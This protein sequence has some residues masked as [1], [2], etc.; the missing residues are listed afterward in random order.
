MKIGLSFEDIKNFKKGSLESI[1]NKAIIN[2]ALQ[3]LNTLKEKHSKVATLNHLTLK[4]QNYLKGNRNEISQNTSGLIFKMRS[5]VTKVK[6]NYKGSFDNLNCT[7]CNEEKECQKHI[8]E[9]KKILEM[10]EN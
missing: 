8:M 3:R 5:K 10:R 1:L 9:C 4:M 6:M 2:R 7:V